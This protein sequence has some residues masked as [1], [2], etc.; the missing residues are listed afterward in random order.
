VVQFDNSTTDGV[1]V[2]AVFDAA[3]DNV[4]FSQPLDKMAQWDSGRYQVHVHLS[5]SNSTIE[6]ANFQLIQ[7]QQTAKSAS[8]RGTIGLVTFTLVCLLL[9]FRYLWIRKL[10]KIN[11]YRL[12]Q[13]E[14]T[15][16][17]SILVMTSVENRQHVE[18]VLKLNAFFK[19]NCG[20]LEVYFAMDPK[21]G[22]SAQ[23]EGDPWRW[24]QEAAA[25]VSQSENGFIL[26]LGS[27]PTNMSLDI[28]KDFTDNQ[29]FVSTQLLR[30]MDQ[31]GAVCVAQLPYTSTDSLPSALPD[32]LRK[33]S[34]KLP[35]DLNRL[36]CAIHRIS[37][38]P[39]FPCIPIKFIQPEVLNSD[40][41][42]TASGEQILASMNALKE[43]VELFKQQADNL[44]VS[45]P[46]NDDD[47]KSDVR[48]DQEEEEEE[49]VKMLVKHVP[50]QSKGSHT[51]GQGQTSPVKV[52]IEANILSLNS[53]YLNKRDRAD[54]TEEC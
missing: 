11:P 26:I 35:Q 18:I 41:T 9:Y 2:L 39:L 10:R 5:E 50:E 29:A 51:E 44:Y 21:T 40:L 43:K 4:T 12:Y 19:A 20:V 36:L 7:N 38:R 6:V 31:K 13:D 14:V 37:K 52:D 17:P 47:I 53:E 28:Y 15:K 27:P 25:K 49:K 3:T 24:C 46:S 45:P 42:V 8:I 1:Q 32:H 48:K 54:V 33:R 22:I 30:D 23:A 16:A 34:G